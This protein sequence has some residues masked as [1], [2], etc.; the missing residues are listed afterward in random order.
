MVDVVN[1]FCVYSLQTDKTYRVG[2]AYS[3]ITTL[4]LICTYIP[5]IYN[6]KGRTMDMP[7]TNKQEKKV[8]QCIQCVEAW[9]AING[10]YCGKLKRY[11]SVNSDV[12]PCHR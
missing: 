10:R 11:V 4:G 1:R 9:N 12:P 6:R 7:E 5:Y 2:L 3:P 8:N